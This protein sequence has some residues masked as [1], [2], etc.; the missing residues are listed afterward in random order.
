MSGDSGWRGAPQSEDAWRPAPDQ[1]PVER[2]LEQDLAARGRHV[3]VIKLPDGR[4]TR[5]SIELKQSG[6]RVYAYLRFY[7]E[8]RTHCRYVGRVDGETR[9]ENL[10]AAW[11]IVMRKSLLVWNGFT[12]NESRAET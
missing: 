2:A 6:R 11:H 7:T 10:A 4:T 8:G 1:S 3:R 5:G 9:Q 12:G